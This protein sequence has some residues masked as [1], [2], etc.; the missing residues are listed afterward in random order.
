M[1]RNTQWRGNM[2]ETTKLNIGDLIIKYHTNGKINDV[3]YIF[4]FKENCERI[5][6]RYW[7]LHVPVEDHEFS[8]K[9]YDSLLRK[10]WYIQRSK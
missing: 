2:E 9:F 7:S 3:Y 8:P 6:I 1:E 5:S 4:N 10:E